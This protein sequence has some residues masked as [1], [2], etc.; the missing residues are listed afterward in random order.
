MLYGTT[1]VG[2]YGAGAVFGVSTDGTVF[3]NLHSFV[4]SDGANPLAGLA[5]SGQMLFG[6][7]SA[8][9][10]IQEGTVFRINTDGTG[11]TNIHTFTAA[12]DS[13]SAFTNADGAT[14]W[15]GSL[16][17][18]GNKL[19]GTC[20]DGGVNGNGTIFAINTDGTGFTNC[21]SF[22]ATS[23]NAGVGYGTNTDGM[24]PYSGLALYGNKLY[25]STTEGGSFGSGTIY[26]IN[27]DGTGF[28]NLYSIAREVYNNGYINSD[29][30]LIYGSLVPLGNTLYGT[31]YLGG[32]Y[33]RGTV[34]S[35]TVPPAPA[36]LNCQFTAGN[37]NLSWSDA[38]YALYIAPKPGGPYVKLLGA[39][40]PYAV[41]VTNPQQF[42]RLSQQ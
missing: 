34:F 2:G 14:P 28:T 10:V 39:V 29:G 25:G 5:I 21:H 3:T 33:G 16:L 24:S 17:L 19:F 6:T 32:P 18:V 40:S 20:Q 4:N 30:Y 26:A 1:K 11:F 37:L 38:S 36:V 9:G 41:G 8:G 35:L 42:F 27:T 31:A 13:G 12:V 23:Y 15:F 7:T 22:T